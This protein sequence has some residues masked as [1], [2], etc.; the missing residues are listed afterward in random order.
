[1]SFACLVYSKSFCIYH[2]YRYIH[3]KYL[4]TNR[5]MLTHESK[6]E[7]FCPLSVFYT[8]KS[9]PF[10][11]FSFRAD[12]LHMEVP[13]SGQIIVTAA[14]LDTTTATRDPSH[15]CNLHPSSQQHWILN[16]LSEARDQTH[17]FMDTSQVR[18]RW[19]TAGS[20][21]LTIFRHQAIR[22]LKMIKC[23][24]CAAL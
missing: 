4:F 22:V 1:M 8:F 12:P 19:A 24:L 6:V 18:Y 11:F 5:Y 23:S 9:T 7:V 20:P 10:L 14:S 21:D 2:I 3:I 16:P 17:I 15:V 13:G